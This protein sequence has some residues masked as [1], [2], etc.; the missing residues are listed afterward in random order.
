MTPRKS[1]GRKIRLLHSAAMPGFRTMSSKVA[2]TVALLFLLLGATAGCSEASSEPGETDQAELEQTVRTYLPL[3]AEAYAKGE[4]AP[5]EQVAVPKEIARAKFQRQELLDQGKVYE[6]H[7]KDLVVESVSTWKHSN[8]FVT[9]VETWDV[10]SFTLGDHILLSEVADQRSR[11]KYQL[12]RKDRG[13]VVLYREL[14]EVL[15]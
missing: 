11:I 8:A 13:W 4:F 5:L 9:T 10:R 12:K 2:M 14:A 7:F 1:T 3:L 15:E 6:P